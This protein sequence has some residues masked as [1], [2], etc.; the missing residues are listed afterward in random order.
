MGDRTR[1]YGAVNAATPEQVAHAQH[2]L[3][4]AHDD[5]TEAVAAIVVR[6]NDID[7]PIE[8]AKAAAAII[9][10]LRSPLSDPV[11][12]LLRAALM[13]AYEDGRSEHGWFGYGALGEQL[14]MSRAKVQ[15]ILTG[16]YKD[17]TKAQSRQMA[18]V[19]HRADARRQAR[20]YRAAGWSTQDIATALGVSTAEAADLTR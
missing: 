9:Q 10:T 16:T 6:L 2:V 14:G 5:L 15:Q 13:Q 17:P 4:R 8:R 19:K 20:R 12:T 7:N 18:E 3:S 11:E 1:P